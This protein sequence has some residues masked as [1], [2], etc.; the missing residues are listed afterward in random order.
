MWPQNAARGGFGVS[1][2][3]NDRLSVDEH[4]VNSLRI[5]VGSLEG[6][7]VDDRLEIEDDNI[8]C[9]A[10]LESSAVGKSQL[11][12]GHFSHLVDSRFQREQFQLPAVSSQYAREAAIVP[13]VWHAS[14]GVCADGSTVGSDHRQRMPQNTLHFPFVDDEIDHSDTTVS[15]DQQVDARLDAI[16]LPRAGYVGH[17]LA[18]PLAV[19]T[20]ADGS[21]LDV[22]P[23]DL[24][25]VRPVVCSTNHVTGNPPSLHGIFQSAKQRAAATFVCPGWYQLGHSRASGVVRVDVD[26]DSL[27][28]AVG[29][30]DHGQRLSGRAPVLTAGCL[31]MRDLHRQSGLSTYLDRLTDGL[32]QRRSFSADVRGI[33]PSVTRGNAG[34][35]HD[36]ICF[37]VDP[38]R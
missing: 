8:G 35:G 2:V 21:D 37:A 20:I 26:A 30:L 34:Q 28:V 32:D 24:E 27:A 38:R 13:G 22:I 18:D 9:L 17:S 16:A 14:G 12:G 7:L 1:A 23:F 11:P 31:V 25:E 5:L 6:G 15:L 36:F 10:D 19:G 4:R 3:Q 29:S 33:L